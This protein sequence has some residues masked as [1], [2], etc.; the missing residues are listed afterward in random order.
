[1]SSATGSIHAPAPLASRQPRVAFRRPRPWAIGRRRRRRG[2]HVAIVHAV[3][4]YP[5]G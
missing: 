2:V 5:P 4:I 3:D 1:M